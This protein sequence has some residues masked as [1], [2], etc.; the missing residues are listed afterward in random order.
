LPSLPPLAAGRADA[1][2]DFPAAWAAAGKD[3]ARH[4]VL[5]CDQLADRLYLRPSLK[6]AADS[7]IQSPVGQSIFYDTWLQHGAGGDPDSLR[8]ILKRA[9]AETG[10]VNCCFEAAFLRAFLAIRKAVLMEPA[11]RATREVWRA[12]TDRVDALVRLLDRNPDLVPP[13]AVVVAAVP[14]VVI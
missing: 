5:A 9:I 14:V 8:A 13:I 2:R 4:L 10:G 1:L 6:A 12:S 7:G 11:N 3:D